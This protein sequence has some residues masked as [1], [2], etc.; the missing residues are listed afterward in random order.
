MKLA[1]YLL[2][3]AAHWGA[4]T[5]HGIAPLDP[6]WPTLAEG[7]AAGVSALRSRL[8][9]VTERVNSAEM[10]WLAP[11]EPA[12]RILCVGI[13][14]GLH[15]KEMGREM[16][17]WPSV[18]VRLVDSFVGHEEPVLCP[19]ASTEFDYE[20]ELAVVIGRSGRH[21]HEASALEH[22]GGYTCLSDNS[23]RD[24]QKHNAQVTPG[25]NFSRSGAIGPWIVTPDEIADPQQLEVIARVNGAVMQHGCTADMIFP[26]ARIISYISTFTTLGPG[27]IIA[28]GTPDGVGAGR[29]PPVWLRAGDVL[30]IDIPGIGILRN[31]VADEPHPVARSG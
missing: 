16:P 23:V 18:F 14:Y 7:L 10:Q 4:V 26:V 31:P 27:D 3:G 13:N 12:T 30:E 1:S 21:V 9:L 8:A 6:F 19:F 20:A 22:V 15:V 24:F 17:V 11:I 25:K 29:T 28:T 2:D 5:E